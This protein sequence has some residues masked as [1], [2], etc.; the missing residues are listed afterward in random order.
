MSASRRSTLRTRAPLIGLIGPIGCGKSTVAGWLAERGAAII[1]ADQLTRSIMTPGSPATDAIVARFGGEYRLADG[2]LDRAA[3]GHLVFADPDRLAELEAIVHPAVAR[4]QEDAILAAEALRPAAIVIEAIKLVEAGYAGRCDEVWLVTCEPEAQLV[5]LTR[6][7]MSAS[8]AR[9]RI[10]AQSTSLA[11]W[12]AA[13]TRILCTDGQ[14]AAV[15]LAVAAAFE[16]L[17]GTR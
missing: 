2:S 16:E 17:L 5:R 11:L 3:L 12:R 7:G 6:R 8:D 10:A 15:E 4:L 13:A 14:P 1:D 9:Q